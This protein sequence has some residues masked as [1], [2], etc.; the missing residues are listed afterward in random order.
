[1]AQQT[2]GNKLVGSIGWLLLGILVFI[3]SFVLLY[4][5]EGRTNYT[6]I[7]E[8]A[9]NVDEAKD[10]KDFVYITRELDTSEFLG[11]GLFL[12]EGDYLVVDRSVDMYS[13]VE[14]VESEN[15][16]KVYTYDTK[17]VED[18]P[19]SEEFKEPKGHENPPK[20]VKSERYKVSEATVGI[21][22]VDMDEINLPSTSPL[23]LTED[24]VTL[25]G[26]QEIVSDDDY[27]YI[28]DG[29]GTYDKPEIGDIRVRYSVLKPMDEVTVFGRVADEKI[30]P[31][32]GEA[33]NK[34]YRIFKGTKEDAMAA[35][36]GE[37]RAAGW[38]GRIGVFIMMWIGLLMILS[39][40]STSMELI[41]FLS[42]VG[43]GALTFITFVI[44]LILTI[45]G[46]FVFSILHNTVGLLIVIVIAGAIGF[47]IYTKPPSAKK[48]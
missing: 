47:Y 35:L 18:V 14:E 43:K 38:F 6:D 23:K 44:A 29:Y 21:Y 40:L 36:Q 20:P 39:P 4:Y 45:V 34:L 37:Y 13:W 22:N 41:P 27:D 1:M 42:D 12:Y 16:E 33:E 31:H 9:V 26:Y 17:W 24:N 3:G 30:G 32:H 19:D 48:T 46:T 8:T 7:A 25:D 5:S 10:A 2:F 15:D 28:F 11:D